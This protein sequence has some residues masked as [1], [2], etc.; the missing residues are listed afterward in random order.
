V[1]TVKEA[2][3]QIQEKILPVMRTWSDYSDAEGLTHAI[4]HAIH[5]IYPD[6]QDFDDMSSFIWQ[7][8]GFALATTKIDTHSSSVKIEFTE[9]AIS[10]FALRL[11]Q[12]KQRLED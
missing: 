11:A 4:G 2:I 3:E 10:L 7:G 6:D 9:D 1:P 5:D 8:Y 12:W